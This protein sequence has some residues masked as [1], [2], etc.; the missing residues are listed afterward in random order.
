M[1]TKA[2]IANQIETIPKVNASITAKAIAI[3]NHSHVKGIPKTKLVK[4]TIFSHSILIVT[5]TLL[6]LHYSKFIPHLI[7]LANLFSFIFHLFSAR[8]C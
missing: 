4:L 6:L 1:A 2:P 7:H 8:V 3:Q 5:L